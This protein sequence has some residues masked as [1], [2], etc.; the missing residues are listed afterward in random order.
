MKKCLLLCVCI[1]V[2]GIAGNGTAFAQ[3]P[4]PPPTPLP[5]PL[6]VCTGNN[7]PDLLQC[8]SRQV[9]Q[10]ANYNYYQY[11]YLSQVLSELQVGMSPGTVVTMTVPAGRNPVMAVRYEF[12]LGDISLGLGMLFLSILAVYEVLH[13]RIH[14]R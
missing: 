6:P 9:N 13:A 4:T 11:S 7:V 10:V 12:T 14:G 2:A 1:V 3:T 5:T 8:V